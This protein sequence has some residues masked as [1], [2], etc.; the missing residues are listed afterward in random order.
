MLLPSFRLGSGKSSCCTV[1]KKD[2]QI[3]PPTIFLLN[4]YS[5]TIWRIEKKR[6]VTDSFA[7]TFKTNISNFLQVQYL[8]IVEMF[9]EILQKDQLFFKK[10]DFFR[11]IEPTL[12]FNK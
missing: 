5:L 10:I 4:F 6:F 2:L 7:N 9:G 8:K 11:R 3:N 1:V 12:V